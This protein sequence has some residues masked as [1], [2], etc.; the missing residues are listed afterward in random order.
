MK[1]ALLMSNGETVALASRLIA[2]GASVCTA[3]TDAPLPS[4]DWLIFDESIPLASPDERTATRKLIGNALVSGMPVF[5]FLSPAAPATPRCALVMSEMLGYSSAAV[6]TPR[7]ASEI[8]GLEC[9]YES[10]EEIVKV[11]GDDEGALQMAALAKEMRKFY[12]LSFTLIYDPD[13]E[14]GILYTGE[15]FE[16]LHAESMENAV[17]ELFR[18]EE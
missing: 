14:R 7:G 12:E 11:F 3:Q 4:S 15:S 18:T 6:A 17:S 5:A 9:D 10:D 16:E 13:E 1:L 8:L 2:T